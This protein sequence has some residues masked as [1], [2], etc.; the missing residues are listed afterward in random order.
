[1][2]IYSPWLTLQILNRSV[3]SLPVPNFWPAAGRN[4]PPRWGGGE[5]P[6]IKGDMPLIESDFIFLDNFD[7][8]VVTEINFLLFQK[9][10]LIAKSDILEAMSLVRL[11]SATTQKLVNLPIS[12]FSKIVPD[13]FC[14][15]ERTK[16]RKGKRSELSF[17]FSLC[18]WLSAWNMA[19]STP[20]RARLCFNLTHEEA[21]MLGK[22]NVSQVCE[23]AKDPAN[24]HFRLRHSS[25]LLNAL[26]VSN[27][28]FLKLLQ[29]HHIVSFNDEKRFLEP[30]E[31]EA[32]VI[33]SMPQSLKDYL[34]D[35][36]NLII[37]PQ[38]LAEAKKAKAQYQRQLAELLYLIGVQRK[39]IIDFLQISK[40]ACNAFL[41]EYHGVLDK[42]TKRLTHHIDPKNQFE[43]I[44]LSIFAK[45]Y[46]SLGSD[47]IYNT[48]NVPA[49]AMALIITYDIIS[50]S[51]Y[52]SMR[53]IENFPHASKMLE[54]A[55]ALC[56]RTAYFEYCYSTQSFY[57]VVD[58]DRPKPTRVNK[59]KN[60][61]PKFIIQALLDRKCICP[62]CLCM[63]HY[64]KVD[65]K[66]TGLLRSPYDPTQF[67]PDAEEWHRE[68][69]DELIIQHIPDIPLKA[70]RT[71]S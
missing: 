26:M 67:D 14:A 23:Y 44:N 68:K 2:V 6:N 66:V 50:D 52:E 3:L 54:I 17:D 28:P 10:Q 12:K 60:K 8:S 70:T 65:E 1:M 30:T 42:G 22:M 53:L 4:Y 40:S 35:R 31:Y 7:F 43:A 62:F 13:Y 58:D 61:L 15:F 33:Q 29:V 9:L 71:Q 25:A 36:P 11:D 18:Y 56:R 49:L 59:Q 48:V 21:M 51:R 57:L 55:N 34:T 64:L 69:C 39:D 19:S 5:N 16:P 20:F 45:L 38:T 24:C 63:N 41:K 46:H 47:E 37:N 32:P 27:E